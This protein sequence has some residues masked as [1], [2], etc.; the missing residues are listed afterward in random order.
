MSEGRWGIIPAFVGTYPDQ[1]V[2][3]DINSVV[4]VGLV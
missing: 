4:V 1:F 3:I 2:G